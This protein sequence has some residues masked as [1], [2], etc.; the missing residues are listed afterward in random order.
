MRRT[1][2]VGVGQDREELR[3]RT[4]EDSWC[5]DVADGAGEGGGHRLQRLVSSADS[6]GLDE[7]DAEVALVAVC[8]RE[9]ILEHGPD[10]TIVEEAGRAVDDV[11]GLGLRV[12]DLDATGGTEDRA[13]W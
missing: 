9:L 2:D 11:K 8:A 13:G 5:I 12:V 1:G 10:E 7:E 6:V 3:R 4:P